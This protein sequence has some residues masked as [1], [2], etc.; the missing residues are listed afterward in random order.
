MCGIAGILSLNNEPVSDRRLAAMGAALA[1]RGPDGSK[2]WLSNEAGF[3]HARLSIIDLSESADQPM[4]SPD[5]RYVL[6]YNGE[7]YNY[8]ELKESLRR[9]GVRFRTE[10]DTEVV[11][12]SLI[13]EGEKA[14]LKFNGMFALGLW[15]TKENKLLLARDRFGVKPL[16]YFKDENHFVFASEI[17][18]ILASSL[19]KAELSCAGL[20]EYFTFQNFLDKETLFEDVSLFPSGS[21]A[22]IDLEKKSVSPP[23]KYW[24]FSFQEPAKRAPTKDLTQELRYHF[25]NAV[26]NQMVSDVGFGAYLSGGMDS[27]AITAVAAQKAGHLRSFTCGFDMEEIEGRESVF[28]EREAAELMSRRFGTEHYEVIVKSTDMERV[29]PTVSYHIEEPRVGQSY[30]NYCVSKLASRFDK[31]VL[32]GTGG[33]ELF[34]GYN[35]RY[36]LNCLNE[37]NG[38]F[39]DKYFSYW[40]R[41]IPIQDHAIAFSPIGPKI[42]DLN[43]KDRF[44]DQ[45]SL[46]RNEKLRPEEY[47]N[48]CLTFEA[49]FFLNGLLLVE[50]KLAMAC[51]LETRVPFLDNDLVDFASSISAFDKLGNLETVMKLGTNANNSALKPFLNDSNDGKL[52]LRQMLSDIIP[53]EIINRRK[54]GFSAPDETWFRRESKAF[55]EKVVKNKDSKIF[56]YF[57]YEYVQN[58]LERHCSKQENNRLFLWSIL[59]FD[60]LLEQYF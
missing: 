9:K 59:N 55:V 41:L 2:M 4:V 22:T 8:K 24:E 37:D 12:W 35:W 11:L 23:S 38:G 16:Y 14:L 42:K 40:Q 6:C 34:A 17:K 3:Y 57:N 20:V 60:Q 36:Y 10:S 1:H 7:L 47:V 25:E 46:N 15:D 54:Q 5:G 53:E 39:L 48:E 18:S 51:G 27:G 58:K 44:A 43:L 56:A 31:V 21:F 30:P 19:V 26:E 52:I 33:D 32:T 29:L 49:N 45:F 13:Q 50:V 28:D